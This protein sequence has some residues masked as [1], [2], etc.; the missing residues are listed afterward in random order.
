MQATILTGCHTAT[1]KNDY[2][3]FSG[4]QLVKW[5]KDLTQVVITDVL[6]P[7]VCSRVYAYSNIAAYEA[8]LPAYPGTTSYANKLNC[9]QAIKP[10]DGDVKG[11][12]FAISGIIAFSTV[13]QKLVFN[14]EAILDLEAEYLEALGSYGLDEKIQERSVQYGREVG[15][16]IIEWATK[17]GYLQRNSHPAYI[18]T[19]ATG[20]W[21]PTP[22]DYMD[23]VEPNWNT[24][25][26]FTLDSAAQFRPAPPIPFDTIKGSAYY[27]MVM[28]VYDAAKKPAASHIDV[29]KFWDCNPNISV[30]QGHVTYFQQKISPAGHWIHVAGSICEKEQY[31]LVKT[32]G[33][34]SKVAIAIADGFISCWEAKYHYNTIRPETVINKYI[35]KDWR[36]LLQTPPFPEYPSGH[37]VISGAASS[38]LTTLVRDNYAY[39]DS[40]ELPFGMPS[41]Q[42]KSFNEAANEASISRLYGG[43]HF[44]PAL[45]NGLEEGRKI[46]QHALGKLP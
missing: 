41:R 1:S 21:V 12:D 33:I 4:D 42:F 28:E 29:A 27:Q 30:T 44:T 8:L 6:T 45:N 11:Y 14:S 5:N 36:P 17:D 31:D 22:P 38:V 23:A 40:T 24:L 46:A 15:Q 13:A 19:K 26:P 7:P 20:R 18:V 32:A 25:R 39:T 9:L 34:L 3:Q 43:I 2:A 16:Q 37:S 10:P 35:D